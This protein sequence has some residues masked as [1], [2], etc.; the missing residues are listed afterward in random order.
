MQGSPDGA[1]AF[2]CFGGVMERPAVA[3]QA[4]WFVRSYDELMKSLK[5]YKVRGRILLWSDAAHC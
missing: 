3:S 4:D 2:I 1:D 5:R